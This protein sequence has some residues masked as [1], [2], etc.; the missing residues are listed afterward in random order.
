MVL[1]YIYTG[2]IKDGDCC[3]KKMMKS[4]NNEETIS[5]CTFLCQDFN[6]VS[7]HTIQCFFDLGTNDFERMIELSELCMIDGVRPLSMTECLFNGWIENDRKRH[8]RKLNG[9]DEPKNY[10]WSTRCRSFISVYRL[11]I[12]YYKGPAKESQ[13]GGRTYDSH[14][15]D[16]KLSVEERLER[17]FISHT[18]E[19][20]GSGFSFNSI[21]DTTQCV[22]AIT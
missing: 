8:R 20:T 3:L 15:E 18:K 14:Y 5:G 17:I 19:F 1:K 21:L 4:R 22:A 13:D 10:D 7:D 6:T 16:K 2:E 11:A 12:K 9:I